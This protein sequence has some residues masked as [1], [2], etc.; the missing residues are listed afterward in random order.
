[1]EHL[2]IP[3]SLAYKLLSLA[4][5]GMGWANTATAGTG[6]SLQESG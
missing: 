4:V 3:I 2:H 1:M 5:E 6:L